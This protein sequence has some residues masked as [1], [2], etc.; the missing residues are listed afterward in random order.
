[1]WIWMYEDELIVGM[2]DNGDG[3]LYWSRFELKQTGCYPYADPRV[4]PR[5]I[6]TRGEWDDDFGNHL[7]L[8]TLFEI[9]RRNPH[10]LEKL[11]SP[12]ITEPALA[13]IAA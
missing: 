5:G 6:T 3:E 1:M 13:R 10:V 4:G 2:E 11:R 7:S 12:V 9:V 8:G